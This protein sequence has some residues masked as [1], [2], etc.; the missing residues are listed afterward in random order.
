M[1]IVQVL[2][3]P[4]LISLRPEHPSYHILTF[5]NSSLYRFRVVFVMMQSGTCVHWPGY[6]LTWGPPTL[7]LWMGPQLLEAIFN[8]NPSDKY[9]VEGV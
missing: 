3:F 4:L 8:R 1:R 5:I 9:I 6:I 7:I 2:S